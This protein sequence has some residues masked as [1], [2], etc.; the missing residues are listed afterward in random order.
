MLKYA[1]IG[2]GRIARRHIDAVLHAPLECV[3]LCDVRLPRAAQCAEAFA[4]PPRLYTDHRTLLAH[5]RP[6]IVAVATPSGSHARIALDCMHAGCHVLIEKPVALSLAEGRQLI[7]TARLCRVQAA[8]CHQ[9]RFNPSV[10][11]V[12]AAVAAGRIGRIL[13]ASAQVRWHRPDSYY[14]A[15]AWRGT[16]AEDGGALMNQCIHD[17]D[18][19]RWMMADDVLEVCG[20]TARLAHPRIEA[21]D[22]GAA[23]IRFLHGGFGVFEGTTDVCGQNLEETLTLFGTHGTLQLGGVSLDRITHWSLGDHSTPPPYAQPGSPVQDVYGRGHRALYRDFIDAVVSGRAP[24]VP[25]QAGL[26]AVE[27]VLGIYR[28]AA[29]GRTVRFPLGD[30]ATTDHQKAVA[31]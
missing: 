6:D 2:C 20:M 23:A 4:Q 9:N 3:A 17:L 28:A 10:A 24:A 22:F 13:Y 14:D 5:E 8:V 27:L 7:D 21:E 25:L 29:D 26:D 16:W 12:H 11:A 15:D 19:M 18:L 30:A 31:V 1:L